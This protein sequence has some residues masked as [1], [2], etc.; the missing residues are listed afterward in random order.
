MPEP[1]T[2]DQQRLPRREVLRLAV[3]ADVDPR[4]IEHVLAGRRVR[5]RAGERAAVALRTAGYLP[6][7]TA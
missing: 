3:A 7:V 4:T 1:L 2:T 6:Q 5:G